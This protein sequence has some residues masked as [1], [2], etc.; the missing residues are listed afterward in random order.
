M[1]DGSDSSHWDWLRDCAK[2]NHPSL[3]SEHSDSRK[4]KF[5]AGT[6]Q[7]QEADSN[8]IL[9]KLASLERSQASTTKSLENLNHLGARLGF[10]DE[11]IREM[12]QERRNQQVSPIKQ[13]IEGT[14][15]DILDRCEDIMA[16]DAP[17][18]T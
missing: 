17:G 13:V 16:A 5:N 12:E 2:S 11:R 10:H 1:V 7:A 9:D 15:D 4:E 14:E 18:A 3:V 8:A 6:Y